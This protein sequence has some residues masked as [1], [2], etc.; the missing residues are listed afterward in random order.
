[1]LKYDHNRHALT[2]QRAREFHSINHPRG[3]SVPVFVLQS[4]VPAS[5]FD[6]VRWQLVIEVEYDTGKYL[7]PLAVRAC[8]GQKNWKQLDPL[9]FA[10]VATPALISLLPGLFHITT[11]DNI[12][13]I[14]AHG[15][16]PGHLVTAGRR[17]DVHFSPFPPYDGRN[18]MMREKMRTISHRNETWVCISVN[19]AKCPRD[20]LRFCQPNSIVLSTVTIP[21]EAFDGIWT[22]SWFGSFATRQRWLY[23]PRMDRFDVTHFRGDHVYS[24][25]AVANLIAEGLDAIEIVAQE[26]ADDSVKKN[27][28]LPKGKKHTNQ[29]SRTKDAHGDPIE[30]LSIMPNGDGSKNDILLWL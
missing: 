16:K 1:M 13:S 30:T 23:E 9:R 7:H 3:S 25:K 11:I 5:A 21:T 26:C 12:A 14:V 29:H 8:S 28:T 19:P 10:A 24:S 27:G 20:S 2:S 18:E 22:L 15:L 17:K 6:N 4:L